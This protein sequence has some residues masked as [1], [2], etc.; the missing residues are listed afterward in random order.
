MPSG[1]K[2]AL[3][4]VLCPII[5]PAKTSFS[6]SKSSLPI[7]KVKNLDVALLNA[8]FKKTNIATITGITVNDGFLE[9]A[10]SNT[11]PLGIDK[12]LNQISNDTFGI[13]SV[14]QNLSIGT[15]ASLA[16]VTALTTWM[17]TNKYSQADVLVAASELAAFETTIGLV[18]LATTG[19]EYTP[20]V[21]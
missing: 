19:I 3:I 9:A 11:N 6:F 5:S 20:F 8:P 13:T 16:D 21:A 1:S 2:A 18:G 7:S 12:T 17:T 14:I 15:N 4:W 10:V